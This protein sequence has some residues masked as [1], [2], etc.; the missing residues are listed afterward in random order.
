MNK[1]TDMKL[2]YKPKFEKLFFS[3]NNPGTQIHGMIENVL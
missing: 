2:S 1:I 3:M